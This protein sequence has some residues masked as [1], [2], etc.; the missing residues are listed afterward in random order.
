MAPHDTDADVVKKP[1]RRAD[2]ATYPSPHPCIRC[3][4]P[5]R[6]ATTRALALTRK[7][8][9]N[10][11]CGDDRRE[12]KQAVALARS[13]P[14]SVC[15]EVK[16]RIAFGSRG[17]GGRR[18]MCLVCQAHKESQEALRGEKAAAPA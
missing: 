8:C 15:A 7:Y 5:I 17:R 10:K 4:D 12:R 3:G 2:R 16:P 14:C 9:G 13:H 18:A 1:K 6:S 11:C